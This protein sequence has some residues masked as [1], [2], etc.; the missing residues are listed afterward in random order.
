MKIIQMLL[1][2]LYNGDNI[3]LTINNFEAPILYYLMY[4]DYERIGFC[5]ECSKPFK[6]T[7]NRQLYCKECSLYEPV[8]TKI[9]VCVDCGKEFEVDGA[10]K[11]SKRCSN[12]QQINNKRRYIKYNEKRRGSFESKN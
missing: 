3:G 1:E 9:I 10:I 6:Q 4:W 2:R 5:K 8:G 7:G 12:C 11:N